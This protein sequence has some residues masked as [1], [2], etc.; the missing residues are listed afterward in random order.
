MNM[1]LSKQTGLPF[2]PTL[3]N[4][5]ANT[6]TTSRP[7]LA[8]DWH[9]AQPTL[10]RWFNTDLNTA[11]APW[12]TPAQFN[13]G[14]AGRGILRGPGR[15]NL[16][17]SV[18]KQFAITERFRLQL[19]GEFFNLFNHPQFNQIPERGVVGSPASRFLNRDFTNSGIR[20]MW[21]QIKFI[22]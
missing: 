1:I 5:V 9:I 2:T 14:N 8:G 15:T 12:A 17:F 10:T 4:S 19:R 6:G 11:G 22:F 16:D 18:L 3:A 13:F 20:G 7:N 21:V